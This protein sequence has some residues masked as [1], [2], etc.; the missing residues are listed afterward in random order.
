MYN[1]HMST[2]GLL[3]ILVQVILPI[4][5]A[6]VTRSTASAGTKAITLLALTGVTQFVSAWIDNFDKFDWKDV[7]LNV[8]V[9]FL[10]SVATHFGLWKPSGV[11]GTDGT[12]SKI[13]A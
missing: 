8:L 3:A 12:A 7:L 5:V 11:T 10:I 4:V 1:Y 6:V 2:L 9:G 13:G